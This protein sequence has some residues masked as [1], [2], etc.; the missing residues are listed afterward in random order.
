MFLFLGLLLGIMWYTLFNV[1]KVV[2]KDLRFLAG[3]GPVS[4]IQCD[5]LKNQFERY[6]SL[7]KTI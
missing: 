6:E 1:I 3:H 5:P 4:I 7:S 2:A